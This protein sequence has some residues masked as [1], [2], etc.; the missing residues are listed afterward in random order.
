MCGG[1]GGSTEKDW[2]SIRNRANKIYR[3]LVENMDKGAADQEVQKIIGEL[4]QHIEEEVC[5]CTPEVLKLLGD[6][7]AYDERFTMK[8][9]QYRC[10]FALFLREAIQVYCDNL[11]E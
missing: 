4:R 3:R 9:D 11:E 8:L 10:G 5:N 7:Y 2:A 6:I 1:I